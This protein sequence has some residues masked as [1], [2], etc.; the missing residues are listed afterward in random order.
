MSRLEGMAGWFPSFSVTEPLDDYFNGEFEP[1]SYW[2]QIEGIYVLGCQCGDATCWPLFCQIGRDDRT[3][4][5]KGFTQPHRPD[6]D[7]S[8][9]G[10]FVFDRDQYS[11]AVLK[12]QGEAGY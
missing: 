4:V 3:T 2:A 11:E 5:W 7:Y 8:L 6:R 9:F 10:P 12:L 1:G